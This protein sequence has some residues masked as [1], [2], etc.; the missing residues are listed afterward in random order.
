MNLD[1][2]LQGVKTIFLD[3]AP[4]IYFI[5]NHPQFADI[6]EVFIEQLDQGNI[7]AVISPV[8]VAESLVNPF[9]EQDQRL[10]Q[11][12][13]DF[14]LRQ[15]SILMKETD[16]NIS[17]KAAQLKASY[18]LKLPDALQ[19]ATAIVTGCDSFLTNDKK[20]SRISELQI[21]VISDFVI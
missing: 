10:Q 16:V 9:K 8:T 3:T 21:L 18:N 7:Q 20:L 12:F 6:V 2:D 5:E 4:I 19:V 14:M 15:Q 17:I 1:N 13:I 11:D